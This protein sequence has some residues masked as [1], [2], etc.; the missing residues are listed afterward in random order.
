MADPD[1]ASLWETKKDADI[2]LMMGE[3]KWELHDKVIRGRSEMVDFLVD[4]KAAMDDRVKKFAL[5]DHL[6]KAPALETVLK[7]LYV[8]DDAL[9]HKP[10]IFDLLTIHDVAA[11]LG[12]SDLTA[13]LASRVG[14]DLSDILDKR[15]DMLEDFMAVADIIVD[16]ASDA[17]DDLKQEFQKAIGPH[18]CMLLQQQDF[19]NLL[20]DDPKFCFDTLSTAVSEITRVTEESEKKLADAEKQHRVNDSAIDFPTFDTPVSKKPAQESASEGPQTPDTSK[21]IKLE[22]PPSAAEAIGPD[23]MRT[24]DAGST[25]FAGPRFS[26][27]MDAS[28]FNFAFKDQRAFPPKFPALSI[29]RGTATKPTPVVKSSWAPTPFPTPS[30]KASPSD[31]GSEAFESC[32]EGSEE[33]EI[34][35]KGRVIPSRPS[36]QSKMT[37]PDQTA[38]KTKTR[39]HVPGSFEASLAGHTRGVGTSDVHSKPATSLPT[40]RRSGGYHLSSSSIQQD[41]TLELPARRSGSYAFGSTSIQ[42]DSLVP[43][44]VHNEQPVLKQTADTNPATGSRT[45]PSSHKEPLQRPAPRKE[46]VRA[47][48]PAPSPASAPASAFAPASVFTPTSAPASAETGPKLDHKTAREVERGRLNVKTTKRAKTS[49]KMY[50]ADAPNIDCVQS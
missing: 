33:G 22:S 25:P 34:R 31:D 42:Q 26:R 29:K 27:G 36:I 2:W 8:G 9:P 32:E 3:E 11:S 50:D 16:E 17:H 4:Q 1:I 14:R 44:E 13:E 5:K 47:P 7:W 46:P 6:F 39:F 23:S 30:G 37:P 45:M 12:V 20:Q 49:K 15:V 28:A 40:D 41:D 21:K 19:C 43:D 10:E 35:E 18:L 38:H 48:S 24:A